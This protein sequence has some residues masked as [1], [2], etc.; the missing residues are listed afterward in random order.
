MTKTRKD[1]ITKEA[2]DKL[3]T[4]LL[5]CGVLTTAVWKIGFH[6]S[7]EK[8]NWFCIHYATRLA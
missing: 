3:G 7:V 2:C 6:S 1:E 5:K 8:T 4:R